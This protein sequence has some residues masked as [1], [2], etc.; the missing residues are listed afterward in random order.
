M[1]KY[2]DKDWIGWINE[3]KNSKKNEIAK[4]LLNNNF[5]YKSVPSLIIL[6]SREPKQMNKKYIVYV[7]E[8]ADHSPD[9]ILFGVEKACHD[10]KGFYARINQVFEDIEN[11]LLQVQG[12]NLVCFRYNYIHMTDLYCLC[13]HF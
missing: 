4:I 1:K 2:F 11:C 10:V 13:P 3:N 9:A 5:Y 8:A 7:D 12:C 6:W